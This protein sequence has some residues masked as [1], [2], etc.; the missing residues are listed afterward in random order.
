M[1]LYHYFSFL[2]I[3]VSTKLGKISI[4]LISFST[5]FFI[6]VLTVVNGKWDK[7]EASEGDIGYECVTVETVLV[8]E[9]VEVIYDPQHSGPYPAGLFAYNE[10]LTQSTLII[11]FNG[12]EYECE[13]GEY[14]GAYIYGGKFSNYAPDFSDCPFII[15][16]S[17]NTNAS[18]FTQESGIYSIKIKIVNETIETS[19]CFKKAVESIAPQEFVYVHILGIPNNP[20]MIETY[21]GQ[22]LINIMSS[23]KTV[24]GIVRTQGES[25]TC[26]SVYSGIYRGIGGIA[27]GFE[28]GF[29]STFGTS[30]CNIYRLKVAN[31][32][33]SISLLGNKS[34]VYDE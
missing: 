4:S 19:E 23:G 26:I 29:I 21:T 17:P 7:A 22:D 28:F 25:A 32:S 13:R 27:D 16:S 20:S 18:L 8:D 12:T 10:Q 5:C 31:D 1:L 3:S 2:K 24:I 34:I 11:E 14:N 30:Y 15:M 33:N 6:R 9:S